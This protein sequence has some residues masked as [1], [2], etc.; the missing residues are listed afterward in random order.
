MVYREDIDLL[1]V[2]DASE[3]P[4][5][6]MIDPPHPG[7]VDSPHIEE[8]YSEAAKGA[9]LIEQDLSLS[10]VYGIEAFREPVVDRL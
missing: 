3:D 10:Q 7:E 6:S 2:C 1:L 5:P 8:T 9:E 4:F